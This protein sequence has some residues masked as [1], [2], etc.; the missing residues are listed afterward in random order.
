MME[1]FFDWAN[2]SDAH[3]DENPNRK[4]DAY[5]LKWRLDTISKG[6]LK[7]FLNIFSFF[8]DLIDN[9]IEL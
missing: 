1:T 5:N 3:I 6:I 2:A 4:I 9:V 8:L 7:S